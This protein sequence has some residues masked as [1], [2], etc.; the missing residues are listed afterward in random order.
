MNW[1]RP[2]PFNMFQCTVINELNNS[3]LMRYDVYEIY[4]WTESY[5][6]E[7]VHIIVPDWYYVR[8]YIYRT[9]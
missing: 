1:S 9:C 4:I 6:E 7:L 2:I 3:L 8:Y 5:N